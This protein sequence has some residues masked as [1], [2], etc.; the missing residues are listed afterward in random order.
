M[1]PSL[2]GDYAANETGDGGH[3]SK[4]VQS[5]SVLGDDSNAAG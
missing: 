2:F 4:V 1:I 3:A 5:R